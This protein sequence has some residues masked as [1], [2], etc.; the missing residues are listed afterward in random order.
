MLNITLTLVLSIIGLIFGFTNWVFS[1]TFPSGKLKLNNLQKRYR[2]A[3]WVRGMEMFNKLSFGYRLSLCILALFGIVIF[4][5]SV[6][7]TKAFEEF[8][9]TQREE[10]SSAEQ[11]V[12]QKEIPSKVK[13]E[14]EK[15]KMR[16]EGVLIDKE[17][18]SKLRA[19]LKSE[20][21]SEISSRDLK[22]MFNLF[23]YILNS[24]FVILLLFWFILEI[25][26][27]SWCDKHLP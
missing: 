7:A 12:P 14:D 17:S 24:S 11:E 4:F 21:K 20:I 6:G 26:S 27:K 22:D 18:V 15:K 9:D 19:E 1:E 8:K 10:I 3:N 23:G 16:G 5:L 13:R 25:S 2:R